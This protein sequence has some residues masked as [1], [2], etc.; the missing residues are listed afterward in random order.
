MSVRLL[1][2]ASARDAAGRARAD[3]DVESVA[4]LGEL[5]DRASTE[6]GDA[7]AAVLSVARVWIDGDEPVAGLAT[8]LTDGAEVAI[9]P[10]VSGGI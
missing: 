6:Y 8:R 2:F 10:P 7:F 4:T 1:L 5:L 3:F 9:L